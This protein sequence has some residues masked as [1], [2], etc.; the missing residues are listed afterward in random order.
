MDR[1]ADRLLGSF[2]IEMVIEPIDIKISEAIMNFQENGPDVSQRVFTGCGKPV[3]GKRRRSVNYS[4]LK[5]EHHDNLLRM[6]YLQPDDL[7]IQF[8]GSEVLERNPVDRTRRATNR[9]LKFE[10]LDFNNKNN[11]EESTGSSSNNNNKK[12]GKVAHAKPEGP[13]LEKLIKDI[14]HIV[15][16]SKR[17]WS[18][19][20]YQICNND[21]IAEAPSKEQDCWNGTAIS[22]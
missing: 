4:Q 12:N 21:E 11:Q 5:S 16:E 17:F 13:T 3:L 6:K 9:E 22:K 14:R 10:T 1:I 7:D 2:N 15:K 18:N 8:E 20:P 19:L